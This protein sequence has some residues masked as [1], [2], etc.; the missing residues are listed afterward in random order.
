[1]SK[2]ARSS[3]FRSLESEL[4]SL[5]KHL[6][7][8]KFNPTGAYPARVITRTTAYRVLTHAEFEEYI[9]TRVWELA[10][11]SVKA[12][13]TTGRV[14]R[15]VACLIA[16][17]G[18][19]LEYP[20]EMLAPPGGI[21]R[22]LW[23]EKL[24][25]VEKAKSSLTTFKSIID[26]NHG[27]REKNLLALLLPVGIEPGQ[28]DVTWLS[29]VDSFGQQRGTVAHHSASSYRATLLPDPQT[30]LNTVRKILTGLRD[31]DKRLNKLRL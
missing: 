18:K 6:L 15:V 16:F 1:M 30:E 24:E 9:E 8:Q 2:S 21:P 22:S 10:F 31:I 7:P 27:I 28:L 23:D 29:T 5:R 14:N 25:F 3:Q 17:S 13:E 4:R 19:K 11:S 12:L 20:P 26:Q